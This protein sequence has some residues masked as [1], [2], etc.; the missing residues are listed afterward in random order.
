MVI[1][2]LYLITLSSFM[3]GNSG[4]ETTTQSVQQFLED[5]NTKLAVVGRGASY[6]LIKVLAL[7]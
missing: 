7:R 5:P 1:L 2:A 3:V 4:D 6:H